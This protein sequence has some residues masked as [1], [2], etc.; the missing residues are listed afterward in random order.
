[1]TCNFVADG[2]Y[3]IGATACRSAGMRLPSQLPMFNAVLVRK[4]SGAHTSWMDD[5]GTRSL[6]KG[7]PSSEDGVLN[8][9]LYARSLKG[10]TSGGGQRAVWGAS[11]GAYRSSS[12]PTIMATKYAP[13]SFTVLVSY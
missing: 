5:C 9:I 8:G 6:A 1:M 12:S 4:G 7:G 3:D 10:K 2:S 13:H 11:A